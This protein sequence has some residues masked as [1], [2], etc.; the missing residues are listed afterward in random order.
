MSNRFRTPGYHPFRKLKTIVAG[1]RV[2]V[3]TDFSVTYKVIL[4]VP[5]L[6]AAVLFR[7]WVDVISIVLAMG[8][9]LVAELFNSAIE[10][11]CDFVEPAHN[12]QIKIIKDIA[13]AAA[14]MSIL[15]WAVVLIIE[16]VRF[17]R[18]Y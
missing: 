9:V 13:A 17:I 6:G 15:V 1:L 2:A 11:L 5:V 10:V 7:Q 12:E 18:A 8:L 16:I 4:S 3:A 14:G